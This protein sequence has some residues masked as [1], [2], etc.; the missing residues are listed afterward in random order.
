[1]RSGYSLAQI[2]LHWMIACL[3]VLQFLLADSMEDAFDALEDTGIAEPTLW[4]NLHIA[5]GLTIFVLM[6]VRLYLRMTRG[7]PP[8][9]AQ[10]PPLMQMGAQAV[11]WAFYAMLVLLPLSGAVAY[12]RQSEA[13]AEV[14]GVLKVI[15]LVLIG[16]HVAGALYH[17]LV[18]RTTLLS[19]MTRPEN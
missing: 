9:P 12:Y 10:E 4:S 11:H 19:R 17:R 3:V 2:V 13:A 18:L 5:G 6:L 16:L 15:L 1:M 8:A 7:T 14:H